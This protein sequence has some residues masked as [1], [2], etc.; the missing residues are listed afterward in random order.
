M[1]IE[2]QARVMPRLDNLNVAWSKDQ[3]VAVWTE[4]NALPVNTDDHRSSTSCYVHF[5]AVCIPCVIKALLEWSDLLSAC[6]TQAGDVGNTCSTAEGV[7][8][9]MTGVDAIN[10]AGLI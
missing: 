5:P 2:I 4:I 8:W 1:T 7:A 6:S 3:L 9:S 10:R